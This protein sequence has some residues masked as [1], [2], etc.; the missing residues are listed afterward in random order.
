[1]KI[2]REGN[3]KRVRPLF[4]GGFIL[5]GLCNVWAEPITF[6]RAMEL[7]KKQAGLVAS[8]VNAKSHCPPEDIA[9][10]PNIPETSGQSNEDYD[11]PLR[12]ISGGAN[13]EPDRQLGP[14]R[15]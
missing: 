2:S 14:F 7:S 4:L 8:S 10:K 1:M 12:G 15:R 11:F 9:N 3:S 13:N 6:A 5:L